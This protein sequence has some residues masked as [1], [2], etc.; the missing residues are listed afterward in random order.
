MSSKK[1]ASGSNKPIASNKSPKAATKPKSAKDGK[2]SIL[3]AAARV[4]KESGEPMKCKPIVEK[5]IASKYWQTDGKT[6]AATLSSAMLR[7]I[8]TKGKDS[9]F[10]KKDRGL[11]SL[12]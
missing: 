3:D 2:L 11:F 8:T 5:M 1:K 7:E 12:A 10:Q 4:L 6:P 9:R